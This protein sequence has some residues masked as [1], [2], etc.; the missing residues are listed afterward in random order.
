RAFKHR[1]GRFGECDFMALLGQPEAHMTKPGA[2]IQHSQ[3][4]LRQR[5]GKIGLQ[6]G[7]PDRTFAAAIDLF[8]EAGGQLVE[9]AITHRT[10]RRS[11]SL[12]L[13]SNACS[14][15]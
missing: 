7:K 8:G 6:D 12:S 14:M 1:F 9:M 2:N 11:L 13:A 3:R 5:L 10:K 4:A 15:S